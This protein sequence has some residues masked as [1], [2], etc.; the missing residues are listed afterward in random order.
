M[1]IFMN[2]HQITMVPLQE[3][4]QYVLVNYYLNNNYI[5]CGLRTPSIIYSEIILL[6]YKLKHIIC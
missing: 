2:Y 6:T 3:K 4:I 1:N 5:M